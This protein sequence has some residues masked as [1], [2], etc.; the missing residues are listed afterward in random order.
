MAA[1]ADSSTLAPS[2]T[3]LTNGDTAAAMLN[4]M[5]HFLEQL[6]ERLDR[7]EQSLANSVEK[8]TYRTDEVAK[9]LGRSEWTVRDWCN[10]GRVLG[11]KKVHGRG[12]QGEWR[13]PHEELV[14]LQNEGP[15]PI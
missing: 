2:F 12:R 14:R 1:A 10:K 4:R 5:M 15:S 8:E 7:I 13:I 11:A 3:G 6:P 9:R